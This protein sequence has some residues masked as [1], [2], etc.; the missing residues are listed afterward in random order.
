M[1]PQVSG[2]ASRTSV[3]I[4]HNGRQIGQMT[5]HTFSPILKKYIGMGTV[6]AEYSDIGSQVEVEITVEYSRKQARATIVPTPF[7]DPERKRA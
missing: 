4:Y 5:S 3:P 6:E 7:F 1:P 2:H